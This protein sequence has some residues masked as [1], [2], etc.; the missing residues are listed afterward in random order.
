VFAVK[1]VLDSEIKII[2]W[3]NF[4][5]CKLK[6]KIGG[7]CHKLF[8][9]NS[10]NDFFSQYVTSRNFVSQLEFARNRIFCFQNTICLS[11]NR[12]FL[13]KSHILSKIQLFNQNH[14]RLSNRIFYFTKS[15]FL[16]KIELFDKI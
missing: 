5:V 16:S 15:Y 6:R 12:I 8:F 4:L 7:L 11:K 9:Q 13:Q 14:I 10:K 2:N 1:A 3:Q